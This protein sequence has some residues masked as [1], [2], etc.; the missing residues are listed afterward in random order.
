MSDDSDDDDDDDGTIHPSLAAIKRLSEE[1]NRLQESAKEKPENIN[2]L[3]N[4]S[5]VVCTEAVCEELV[6]QAMEIR[7]KY[8]P[9]FHLFAACHTSYSLSRELSQEEITLLGVN[10]AALMEYYREYFPKEQ[11]FPKLHILVSCT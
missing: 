4:N 11:V 3:C 10:I 5:M 7:D 8:K 9:L 1:K 6:P 2:M